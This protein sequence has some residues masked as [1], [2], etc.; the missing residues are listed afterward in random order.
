MRTTILDHKSTLFSLTVCAVVGV[1]AVPVIIPH[2]L[3][4]YHMAHIALHI[5]GLTLATFLAVLAVMSYRRT[6]S[7]RLAISSVAFGCFG[8]AEAVL[9]TNTTW[10]FVSNMFTIPLE[11]VGHLLSFAALGLLALA[12]FRNE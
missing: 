11:E 5:G 6:G 10:P 12:V 2:M 4:G 9:L 3:H 7:R 8:V 1:L